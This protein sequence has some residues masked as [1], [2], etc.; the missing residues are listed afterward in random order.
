M[1]LV[2]DNEEG[3]S[4]LLMALQSALFDR[5]NVTGKLVQSMMPFGSSVRPEVEIDFE[6]GGKA[7]SLKKEF[8]Q[9][10]AALLKCDGRTWQNDSVEEALRDLFGFTPP[11]KG[12]AKEEH[13]GL[14]GLLWVEQ[15][16]TFAPLELNTDSRTALQEAIEGEVGQVLGGERGRRLLATV[17]ERVGTFYTRTGRE[18]EDLKTAR[19]RAE[20]L[21]G[22]LAKLRSN[23]ATYDERVDK[24]GRLQERLARYDRDNLL[25]NAK[26]D[27]EKANVDVNQIKNIEGL[28]ATAVAR[29]ESAEASA[30]SAEAERDKRTNMAKAQ[31]NAAQE[32]DAAGSALRDLEPEWGA[33]TDD[34]ASAQ[35]EVAERSTHAEEA[36][37]QHETA[38]RRM[39]RAEIAE[40]LGNLRLQEAEGLSTQIDAERRSLAGMSIDDAVLEE[41]RDTERRLLEQKST[42]E[43]VAT[44]LDFEPDDNKSVIVD[45]RRVDALTPLRV[46]DRTV[47]RLEGFGALVVTPGG[48]DIASRHAI[49]SQLEGRLRGKLQSRGIETMAEAETAH[50]ARRTRLEE[51][52]KLEAQLQGIAPEG[53]EELRAED[54]EKRQ[55]LAQYTIE[56]D[57]DPLPTDSV[58]TAE[59]TAREKQNKAQQAVSDAERARDV[60]QS[61]YDNAKERW[62][63]IGTRC[64][65]M[66]KTLENATAALEE[67]KQQV[68]DE[69]LEERVHQARQA[70]LECEDKRDEL[71]TSLD[72]FVPEIARAEQ[73][74]AQEAFNRLDKMV[75]TDK[76]DRRDLAIEL[77]TLGQTGLAEEL[78]KK[79]GELGFAQRELERIEMDAKA[80][81]LL[82]NELEDAEG[83]AKAT[84]LAP[85]HSRLQPYLRILLPEADLQLNEDTLEIAGIRRSG[86][87]EPFS[88]LSIGAREQ[89]AVLT[90]LALADF[91]R[92]NGKP[93]SLIL[94]DPLVNS[95]DERFRRMEIALRKAAKN[96][97]I[98][99]LTCHEARY[100]TLGAKMI[101][102]SD[103]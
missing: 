103:C 83:K 52:G 47:V 75:E 9:A 7:Y 62:I 35:Q 56:R 42:L 38:R 86:V 60:I 101:R 91:L 54:R 74:R 67:A 13:R 81:R 31:E 34:L 82:L 48:E 64:K 11:G 65:L 39:R 17:K 98:I 40:A 5:H 93:V 49:I 99:I 22:E 1:V 3:K 78:E 61:R 73:E 36:R 92:E 30:R 26:A 21:E 24:L 59:S 102:L 18:R 45:G 50:R 69:D 70:L 14:A 20:G 80:W 46:I 66:I 23:I 87:D 12:A 8:G 37:T 95:D 90:R 15:G 41:L 43:A 10:P 55:E 25:G 68:T 89:I 84:F 94:D 71:T 100:T 32:S 2:G 4:T 85:V 63:E 53:I 28:I 88:S 16:R 77:R 27:L 51:V 58:R 44:S 76:R 57:G 97:Q 72:T 96:V 6:L 79:E 33:V 29:V 19:A